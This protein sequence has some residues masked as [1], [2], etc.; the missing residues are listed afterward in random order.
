MLLLDMIWLFFGVSAQSKDAC[1]DGIRVRKEFRDMS[2]TDW[3]RF[4]QALRKMRHLDNGLQ[5]DKWTAT[6]LY[7]SMDAHR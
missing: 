2:Y 3:R 5:Y 1:P 6:H 4:K 7:H